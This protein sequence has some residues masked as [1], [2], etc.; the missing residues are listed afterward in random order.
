MKIFY[1][2]TATAIGWRA[3]AAALN[4][5][6]VSVQLVRDDAKRPIEATPQVCPYSNSTHNNIDVRMHIKAEEV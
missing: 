1:K 3:G 4:D 5:G 6:N 2:T